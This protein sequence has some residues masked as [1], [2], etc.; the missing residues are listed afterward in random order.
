[1]KLKV[2]IGIL[3]FLIA[4][5]LATI[6]TFLY[7]QFSR[8]PAER[9]DWLD[10]PAPMDAPRP[11]RVPPASRRMRFHEEQREALRTL[12]HEFRSETEGLQDRARELESEAFE[13]MQK[14]PVA[15][16]DVD[17]LLKELSLVQYEISKAAAAKLIEAKEVLP[18]EQQIHFFNA[19]RRMHTGMREERG[20]P[21]S[22]RGRDYHRRFSEPDSIRR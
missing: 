16:T 6:G 9:V 13:L 7:V 17:S 18:P 8:G 3:V 22:G 19:I 14:D 2:L 21:R 20:G 4:V 5:N 12:L 15:K 10:G 1:M 11:D